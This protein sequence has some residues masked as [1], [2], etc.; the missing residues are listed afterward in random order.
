MPKGGKELSGLGSG[1]SRGTVRQ[2]REG[3]QTGS[4]SQVS[5]ELRYN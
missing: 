4:V 1:C 2:I 3:A 5:L